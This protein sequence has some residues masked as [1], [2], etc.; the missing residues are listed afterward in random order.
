MKTS[1]ARTARIV[2][3]FGTIAARSAAGSYGNESD[4]PTTHS[5]CENP[6]DARHCES[7]AVEDRVDR[8]PLVHCRDEVAD[9]L[10]EESSLGIAI[11]A[12]RDQSLDATEGL[13]R[14]GC[15]L[16]RTFSLSFRTHAV[17]TMSPSSQS[18][19]AY[20]T[21]RSSARP[22]YEWGT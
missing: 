20:P 18:V 21:K 5:A 13:K 16:P 6:G 10:D 7:L 19:R 15:S 9:A 8:E 4:T 1:L 22:D 14:R 11:L 3:L 12:T 17:W 2:T